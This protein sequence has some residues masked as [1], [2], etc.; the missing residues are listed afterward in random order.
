M[1]ICA[2]STI[3]SRVEKKKKWSWHMQIKCGS[4]QTFSKVRALVYLLWKVAVEGTFENFGE[5][6]A[7]AHAD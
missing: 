6:V 1:R 5:R 2:C 4:S 3:E 7:V